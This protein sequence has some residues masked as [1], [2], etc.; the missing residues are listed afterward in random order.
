[1]ALATPIMDDIA[2]FD[3]KVGTT[4]TFVVNGGDQVV[5]NE[6]RISTNSSSS[7]EYII[8]QNTISSY[9]LEHVIPP[10][11]SILLLNGG[12]YKISVR[13]Y[14][15]LNNTSEWSNWQPFYCYTT[16]VISFNIINGQTVYKSNVDVEF[17]YKQKEGEKV[18]YALIQLYDGNNA[19]VYSSGKMYDIGI[20]P[21]NFL[22]ELKN[23]NNH[24]QYTLVG[25]VVTINGTIVTSDRIIFFTN[26][27]PTKEEQ[28]LNV[29]LDSCNGYV[30]LH[31]NSFSLKKTGISNPSPARYIDDSMIDLL[32]PPD[33]DNNL[34][35]WA[36]WDKLNIPTDFL[37]RLWFYPAKKP[38]HLVT[39]TNQDE[40]YHVN[41]SFNRGSTQDYIS[42]RTD[43][44]TIIDK[45]IGVHCNGHTKIFLWL[46][47]LDDNWTIETEVLS[48]ESTIAEWDNV[49]TNIV[50]NA[51]SDIIW[52]GE[53]YETYTPPISV[54]HSV[55]DVLSKIRIGNGIYDA[56]NISR[57]VNLE[58]SNVIPDYNGDTLIGVNFSGNLDT[59]APNYTKL[60]L[61][62]RDV[63]LLRWLILSKATI[64]DDSYTFI[65]YNDGFIPTG[66]E[67]IYRLEAYTDY[68]D[69][70]TEVYT[71]EITPR[72]G[73]VF[74]SDKDTRFAL[75]YAVIYSNHNQNIQNGVLMP[76]GAEYPIVIQN[77]NGN[78]RSGSLQFKVLGY[79]YEVDKRIDRTSIVQETEDILAFLTNGKAKCL[80]DYN[81]NIFLLKVINS[82]QISYD[83]NYGNGISTI[84]FDWVEQGKYTNYNDML[85]LGLL[86][87]IAAE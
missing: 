10:N 48:T 86:D 22:Y 40:D 77:A 7:S 31:S 25:T 69:T 41:I 37:L 38:C 53:T 67:Q 65:N 8:Y 30:N 33:I 16:P 81:G 13:T 83:G 35:S 36:E 45:G 56:L 29:T 50:Y 9:S 79:Q 24:T 2:A 66:I 85:E 75:N 52:G 49:N 72:W 55:F 70:P 61:K 19:I 12:Y 34:S 54:T 21:L 5:K 76:I 84:S 63:N 73:K 51:D 44:G 4:V 15:I 82:P 23:L 18:D 59:N 87:Y 1:M 26:Y 47:V 57:N 74:I 32:S 62:R 11:A 28:M 14:D 80:T 78:Y 43:D 60:V 3:A 71:T 27:P 17:I 46:R 68:S 58:Y 42:I 39:L 20:P 64:S 6:I